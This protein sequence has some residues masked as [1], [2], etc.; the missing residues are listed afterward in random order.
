M[1]MPLPLNVTAFAPS[2]SSLVMLCVLTLPPPVPSVVGLKRTGTTT[3]AIGSIVE[4]M[5]NG[6]V[7]GAAKI[8]YGPGDGSG[9]AASVS[10]PVP[11]F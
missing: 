3:D 1:V 2:G 4:K 5:G 10:G 9:A 11:T 6:Q 8:A 7:G